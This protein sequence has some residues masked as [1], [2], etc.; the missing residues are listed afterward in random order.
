MGFTFLELYTLCVICIAVFEMVGI[1]EGWFSFIPLYLTDK[2]YSLSLF[3][4]NF[5]M[6]FP[7]IL[8]QTGVL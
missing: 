8:N 2:Q 7:V 6:F 4:S 3:F 5:I 1:A